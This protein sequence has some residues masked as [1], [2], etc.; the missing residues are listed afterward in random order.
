MSDLA[1]ETVVSRLE[2]ERVYGVPIKSYTVNGL[3]GQAFADAVAFASLRQ[4]YAVETVASAL[5][6]VVK[7]REGRVS[8]LSEALATLA[9]AI[10]SMDQKESDPNKRRSAIST[11]KLKQANLIFQQYGI[12]QMSLS[13]GQVTYGVAYYKQNDVQLA[14][15]NEQN[16]LQQNMSSLQSLVTKRDKAFQVASRVVAKVNSTL[17]STIQ[18]MGY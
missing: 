15:D 11:E 6:A 7:Q 16:E 8:A 14:L 12:E 4:S 5:Q 2:D 17:S 13:D 10:A 18:A 9:E 3:T 1:I